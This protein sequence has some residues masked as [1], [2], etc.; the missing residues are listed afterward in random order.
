MS[1]K[2]QKRNLVSSNTVSKI[3]GDSSF[4]VST[5][6]FQKESMKMYVNDAPKRTKITVRSGLGDLSEPHRLRKIEAVKLVER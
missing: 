6:L 4:T 5:T 3:M 1:L 2:E